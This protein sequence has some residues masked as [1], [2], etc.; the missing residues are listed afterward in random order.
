MLV[1]GGVLGLGSVGL[2]KWMIER[3]NASL[4]S[5][6]SELSTLL[7]RAAQAPGTGALK[8]IGCESAMVFSPADLRAIAQ[9]LA[10]ERASKKGGAPENIDLHVGE[11]AV[12]V[13]AT[14]S[15]EPPACPVVAAAYAAD[16]H[17]P[18][19]YVVTV[20][21]PSGERCS[22]RFD[23]S[24]APLGSAASPNVPL[25]VEPRR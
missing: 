7:D 18:A 20:Q 11:D 24:G 25:L 9:P 16:V 12:V 14:R 15:N 1:I 19:A 10:D 6:A 21:N 13:C 23:T 2:A 17:P 8:P 3:R 4:L 22:E 5:A